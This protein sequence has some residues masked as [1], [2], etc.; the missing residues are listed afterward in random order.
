MS[1]AI[2]NPPCSRCQKDHRSDLVLDFISNISTA[3]LL[4]FYADALEEMLNSSRD[5]IKY[6]RRAAYITRLRPAMECYMKGIWVG[7]LATP[8]EIIHDASGEKPRDLMLAAL[9]K[10]IGLEVLNIDLDLYQKKMTPHGAEFAPMHLLNTTV[11]MTAYFIAFAKYLSAEGVRNTYDSS[12]K[13]ITLQLA[14][15]RKIYDN[16]KEGKSRSDI[17]AD[18]QRSQARSD[19]G[20]GNENQK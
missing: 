5:D 6:D 3:Q 17:I 20:T 2:P 7:L 11:H 1:D 8:E 16:L 4:G 19:A 13:L 10:K 9:S 14:T 15:L 18:I 12:E